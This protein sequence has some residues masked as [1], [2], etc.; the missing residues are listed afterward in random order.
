MEF[1]IDCASI[2]DRKSFHS[3]LA[4]T[5]SFPDWYGRNLSAL[6]DMLTSIRTDTTLI[7]QNFD[8]ENEGFR[9]VLEDSMAENPHLTVLFV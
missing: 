1:R 2:T 6:H 7:L 9:M 5:L 3:I 4:K 8:P